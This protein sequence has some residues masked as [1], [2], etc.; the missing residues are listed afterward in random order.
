MLLH[1]TLQPCSVLRTVM[2]ATDRV[3]WDT[4]VHTKT[5]RQLLTIPSPGVGGPGVRANKRLEVRIFFLHLSQRTG[6]ACVFGLHHGPTTMCPRESHE[7]FIKVHIT[8][9]GS[10][11]SSAS[12][13]LRT[14]HTWRESSLRRAWFKIFPANTVTPKYDASPKLHVNNTIFLVRWFSRQK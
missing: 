2:Q 10:Y 14:N 5:R 7:Q 8:W 4:E 6:H 13:Q 3:E 11:G 12:Y 1:I 9:S